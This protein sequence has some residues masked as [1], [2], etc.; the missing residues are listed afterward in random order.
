MPRGRGIAD[1]GIAAPHCVQKAAGGVGLWQVGQRIW[2]GLGVGISR[3]LCTGR[4]PPANV[5]VADQAPGR[6]H[7]LPSAKRSR[8]QIGS[9]SLIASIT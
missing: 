3:T 8:F 2:P 4:L 6:F 9:R 1:A 7:S 5:V